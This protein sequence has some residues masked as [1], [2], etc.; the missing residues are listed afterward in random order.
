VL[1]A[2]LAVVILMTGELERG[3]LLA[4]RVVLTVTV[5]TLV[6]FGYRRRR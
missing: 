4:W 3:E 6:M 5:V 2:V 1:V